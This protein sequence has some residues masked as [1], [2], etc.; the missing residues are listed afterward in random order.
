[1]KTF[2]KIIPATLFAAALMT[3]APS[4]DAAT[5]LWSATNNVSAS[6][7][8][9]ASANWLGGI[10]PGP[11]DDA[12]FID[13]GA[14]P[15]FGIVNNFVDAGFG[16]P[17]S[18][19]RYS[20]TNGS[21]T[22]LIASG[23]ILSLVG[24]NGLT[25]GTETDAG[26]AQQVI[27]TLSGPGAG[28]IINNASANLTVRQCTAAANGALRATLDMSDL[29]VFNAT[30][31][32]VRVG[33]QISATLFRATGTLLFARTNTLDVA[34]VFVVGDTAN[35]A[36]GQNIVN[37]GQTN[38]VFLNTLNIGYSKGL[39]LVRFNPALSEPV[40]YLRG[41]TA[42][43]VPAI[44]VGDA[45]I[46]GA[47]TAPT[48]GIL[49]LS[50]GSVDAQVGTIYIGRSQ[51]SGGGPGTGTLSL[52]A[53][54]F[55][56]DITEAGFQQSA[57]AGAAASMGTGT[58]NVG[59]TATYVVN[60]SLRLARYL[61]SGVLPTGTLNITDTAT[62]LVKGS[63]LAGGGTS[64]INMI[65]GSLIATNSGGAIGA[66]GAALGTFNLSDSTLSLAVSPSGPTVVVSGLNNGGTLNPVNIAS[67]PSMAGYPATFPIIKYD[68][69]TGDPA[70]I[71]LGSLPASS[72]AFQGYLTNNT[73]TATIELVITAGPPPAKAISWDGAASG[74]WDA[75]SANWKT[76]PANP[77][78]AYAQGDFVTFTDNLGG[79]TNV[80]L[81]T[82]L[83]PGGITVNNT[84]SNYLFT[85][86]GKISGPVNL[87]KQG[88]GTLILAN[89]GGNDFGGGVV[90]SEG[91]IQVGANGATG[92]LPGTGAVANE[93]SL[94][95]NR[96]DNLTVPNT[97][98]G[99]GSLTKN[100]TGTL[101]LSG[102]NSFGGGLT[103]NTG[104]ARLGA[105]TAAGSGA[106]TVN[107]NATLVA[108][109][110]PANPI[111]LS[112]ATFGAVANIASIASELTA[113][114]A[115]TNII[116]IS[117]PQNLATNSEVNLTGT[118]F[119]SGHV[120][121]L[122]GTNNI[123]PDGGVGFRL[124][125]T[126]GSDFSGTITFGHNVKGELQTPFSG[127]FSPANTGKLILTCGDATRGNTNSAVTTTG[128]YS[129][130]NLRNNSG[131]DALFGNDIELT[132]T[133]LAI[134]NPL[135]TAPVN[136]SVTMGNL[137]IGAGQELGVFLNTG[138][139]HVIAFPTVTLTGGTATFSPKIPGFNP[140]TAVGSD[141]ALG[142]ISQSVAGAGINMAGLRTL[143]ITGTASYTG[144]TTVDSGTLRITGSLG[145]T[146]VAVNN[147]GT[148]DG[149][150]SIAGA[151]AINSGGTI[152]PGAGD[153]GTLAINNNL[154]L[155]GN[156]LIEV[157]KDF[158][159]N[160]V[161]NV[162]GTLTY[163]GVLIA[164]N[165][166]GTP[167]VAGDQF[168]V[169]PAGG[170]GNIL[171]TGS[172][173]AGLAW[174]LD[175]ATGILSVVAGAPTLNYSL[176]NGVLTFNWEGNYR[177]VWQTNALSQGLSNNWE[178]YPDA[179]NPV[180][181]TINPAIPTAFFGLR[182][183]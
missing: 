95:F 130:L 51:P 137:R 163:G 151:V 8:W 56:A 21:H 111:T 182:P 154:T 156:V 99:N 176:A 89:S 52:N 62:V 14:E 153:I 40:L 122:S 148:L 110:S 183:E 128:G 36:A 126:G 2:T 7:N 79:T 16:G 93:G 133:G 108:G 119:G 81:T 55:D 158:A 178:D 102:N 34:G 73:D 24:T 114:N 31:N 172:P 155:A 157:N 173:G 107:N 39:G 136:A 59:G 121:I 170:T 28:L 18:S 17:I 22:T 132:G 165:T 77:A 80:N 84:L 30:L 149:T 146:A 169:F 150:G 58:I 37:F 123:N 13:N 9:S 164:T 76:A 20:N 90:L 71:G 177:L 181:V 174:N 54:T 82:T 141:L 3:V 109:A 85:G 142:D 61:N 5:I 4:S 72:P 12:R 159:A 180:N 35:N 91:T 32:N 113:A 19:L 144:A 26:N 145:N 44:N 135:G 171:V 175:K 147:S 98:S 104:T 115:T 96:S 86:T 68:F 11:D 179:G 53:G 134:V 49:D 152:S 116:Y 57:A 112:G 140:L 167:L 100:G 29:D 92:N 94:V 50:G 101:T 131:G 87:I 88:A 168:Q 143:S 6:T 41:K 75:S 161:L 83:L 67:L 74:L 60:T 70:N 103:V 69:M 33:Q 66:L 1:M 15:P 63:I 105:A 43:R 78:V 120:V 139:A 47:S 160:D 38:A 125:G 25:A 23:V 42:T 10:V 117:D 97:I 129:E 106:I 48:T 27:T 138:N 166:G 65:G 124:R 45:S 46:L 127:F 118:L 64:T 162:T